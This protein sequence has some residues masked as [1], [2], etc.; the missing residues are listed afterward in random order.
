[1]LGS[2]A[3]IKMAEN[4]PGKYVLGRDELSSSRLNDAGGKKVV[5]SGR[6]EEY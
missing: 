6:L 2:Y 4:R 5:I 1:M 3:K